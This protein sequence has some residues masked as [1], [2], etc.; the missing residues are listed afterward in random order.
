MFLIF[1]PLQFLNHLYQHLFKVLRLLSNFFRFITFGYFRYSRVALFRWLGY[2]FNLFACF[3]VIAFLLLNAWGNF[4]WPFL[5]LRLEKPCFSR[6]LICRNDIKLD[7]FG[8]K[9]F[10]AILYRRAHQFIF[11][12]SIG[13][14]FVNTCL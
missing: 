9:L 14:H 4:L 3:L 12:Q 7:F 8:I 10:R 13:C 1:F 11:Y 6:S 5:D 2:R